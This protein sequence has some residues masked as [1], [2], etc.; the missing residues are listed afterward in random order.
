MN[1][2]PLW[3]LADDS[4]NRGLIPPFLPFL[5]LPLF[6]CE[7]YLPVNWAAIPFPFLTCA[8]TNVPT[9]FPPFPIQ[10]L[11]MPNTTNKRIIANELTVD[12]LTTH[13]WVCR[14]VATTAGEHSQNRRSVSL[15]FQN[16]FLVFRN[17]SLVFHNVL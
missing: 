4:T 17:V 2:D 1:T 3:Q 12:C 8:N 16:I 10:I 13:L 11:M 6:P 15:V 9:P 14:L 5:P 7:V